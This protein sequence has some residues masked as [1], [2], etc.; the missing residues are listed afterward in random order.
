MISQK[1]RQELK[2]HL[3]RTWRQEVLDLLKSRKIKSKNNRH[4]SASMVSQVFYG[5]KENLLIE[6]AILDVYETTKNQK[7]EFIKRKKELLEA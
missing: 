3:N 4:Y 5:Q 7:Q 2:E 1:Q 6:A